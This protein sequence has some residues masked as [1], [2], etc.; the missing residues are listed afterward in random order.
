M[1]YFP[2]CT[3]Y[4]K[5]RGLDSSTRAA[6]AALDIELNELPEWTCCGTVFPLAQD[7][8]MGMVAAARILASAAEEEGRR[9]VTVCSFCYNVLKRVNHVIIHDLE[10]R[11]K[12]ND[13]L[14]VNYTG[15][16]LIVH[17]L[18]ICRDIVGFKVIKEKITRSLKGLKV[19]CYYGCTLVRPASEMNFD[20]PEN[21]GIMDDL[22]RALGADT[23][24]HPNKTTCCGSYQVLHDD[25]LVLHRVRDILGSAAGRGAQAI[26]TS[27]PLCQSNLERLQEKM[28]QENAGFRRIP[29][30]YFTQLL[31]AALEIPRERLGLEQHCVDPGPLLMGD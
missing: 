11:R 16:T 23:V 22:V 14:E 2:G 4:N 15:E 18:E 26:V 9:L 19:A 29:V 10:A 12:L 27:C 24:E 6:L 17:P 3:L 21:P 7:N 20:D 5:A 28:L 13:F 31:G 8:Y 25:S 30:L 1:T